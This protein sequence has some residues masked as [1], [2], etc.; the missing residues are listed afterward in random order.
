MALDD[1]QETQQ[2]AFTSKRDFL[3]AQKLAK[4]EMT[5]D[6]CERCRDL[7]FNLKVKQEKVDGVNEKDVR[8][9]MLAPFVQDFNRDKLLRMM[10]SKIYSRSIIVYVVDM[11]NFEASLVPEIFQMIERQ[12][13]RVIIVANKIDAIPQGFK[14][15]SLQLWIKKRLSQYFEDI[16]SLESFNICLVSSLKVTGISKIET[17]LQRMRN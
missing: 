15:D 3:K 4:K 2:G 9:T 13:H 8:E 14:V 5:K 6:L 7:R 17:V 1:L 10:M 12:H 11:T 16:D